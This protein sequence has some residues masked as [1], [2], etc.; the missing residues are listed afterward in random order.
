MKTLKTL[1][2][3]TIILSFVIV[4]GAGHGAGFLGLIEIGWLFQLYWIGTD[5]FSLSLTSSYDKTLGAAAMFAFIGHIV[6]LISFL[7]KGQKIKS[8][9][10]N[11]GI[12]LLWLAFIYIV[13]D[14]TNTLSMI[15]FI[16]GIPFMIVSGLLF[17]KNISRI[18]KPTL[19]N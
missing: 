13:H 16:T 8:W 18:F 11:V 4:I 1:P 6:V 10:Q 5:N 19:E 15:G 17:F 14:I 12:I 3:L 2:A 7:V 9:I